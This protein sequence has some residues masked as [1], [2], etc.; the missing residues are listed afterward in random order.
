MTP[1]ERIY[2]SNKPAIFITTA[3]GK[4]GKADMARK[5]K[6]DLLPL[7]LDFI[8]QEA[9][10]REDLYADHFQLK[11]VD[12]HYLPNN[13]IS[14]TIHVAANKAEGVDI[15]FETF[16][17][18]SPG[19]AMEIEGRDYEVMDNQMI[20]VDPM[21]VK[22]AFKKPRNGSISAFQK[23]IKTIIQTLKAGSLK[24]SHIEYLSAFVRGV[25]G[26]PAIK[27][28][29][30]V[31]TN[32]GIIRRNIDLEELEQTMMKSAYV[33][34][35][36]DILELIRYIDHTEAQIRT[37]KYAENGRH[38]ILNEFNDVKLVVVEGLIQKEEKNDI[39][40]SDYT[41][42]PFILSA[43]ARGFM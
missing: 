33:T 39:L 5:F 38:Y 26:K 11:A 17:K 15:S 29:K 14:N 32:L 28:Y 37:R 25:F 1:G 42:N 12:H 3:I 24:G 16:R 10:R 9:S 4:A 40:P 2:I 13:T 27:E 31:R 8:A 30:T 21:G 43:I 41:N 20:I 19:R 35:G 34:G 18:A 22:V 6:Y 7:D 36:I 23:D